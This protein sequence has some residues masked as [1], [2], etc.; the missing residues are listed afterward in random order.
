MCAPLMWAAAEPS[1]SA[2]LWRHLNDKAKGWMIRL[3]ASVN[4]RLASTW[5]RCCTTYSWS[6]RSSWPL[7]GVGGFRDD[8][9]LEIASATLMFNPR[10]TPWLGRENRIAFMETGRPL[11]SSVR[12]MGSFSLRP[13]C[14]WVRAPADRGGLS[15][16]RVNVLSSSWLRYCKACKLLISGSLFKRLAG[17]LDD[18]L[19]DWP[20][21]I[22]EPKR[23]NKARATITSSHSS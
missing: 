8:S 12:V 9:V 11:W 7:K 6:G 18:T 14:R 3:G 4:S 16:R 19:I 13:H 1:L 20:S 15:G 23:P 10:R 17:W 21:G 5:R 22:A 2:C